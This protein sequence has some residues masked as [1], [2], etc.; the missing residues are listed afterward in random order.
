MYF[1]ES[2]EL[3]GLYVVRKEAEGYDRLQEFHIF[4]GGTGSFESF[5]FKTFKF[6]FIYLKNFIIYNRH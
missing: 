6:Y 5:I 3:I 4:N 2:A 1:T